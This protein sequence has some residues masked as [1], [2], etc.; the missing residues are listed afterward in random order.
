MV[1]V[2]LEREAV[3]ELLLED[4]LPDRLAAALDKLLGD[5]AARNA[6]KVASAEALERLGRGGPSPSERAAEVVLKI[7]KGQTNEL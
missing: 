2:I 3:P 4:C 7:I 5:E 6:Q 1:N